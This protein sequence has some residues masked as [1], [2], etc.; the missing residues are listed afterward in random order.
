MSL[1]IQCQQ[2]SDARWTELLPLL[3]QSEVVR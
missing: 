1:D 3:Q 2:L